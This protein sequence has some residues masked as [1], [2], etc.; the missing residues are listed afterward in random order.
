MKYEITYIG[1]IEENRVEAE[2][3]YKRW[4]KR[5]WEIGAVIYIRKGTFKIDY[6]NKGVELRA[7]KNKI[8]KAKQGLLQYVNHEGIQVHEGLS[9][10]E[11]SLKLL[12]KADGTAM[13]VKII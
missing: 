12:E 8:E 1:N 4:Y 2:I 10:A 6:F 11:H 5:T 3:S 7:L 9:R 13:G